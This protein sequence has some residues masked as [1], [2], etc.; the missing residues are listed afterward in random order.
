MTAVALIGCDGAGKTTIAE[1]LV[2]RRPFPARYVYMGVNA[3]SS[4]ISLP[5]T[6]LVYEMKVRKVRRERRKAGMDVEAPVSLHGLEHR[7]DSR[8]RFW[9]GAR[10]LNR[11][12]EE[13]LRLLVSIWYQMR[14]Y[15]VIYDR[16]FLFDYWSTAKA[17]RLSDRIHE[18]FLERV[19]PE[20]D[21]VLFLDAP[22]ETLFARKPEVPVS[23]LEARRDAYLRRGGSIDR[24]ETVD[25]TQPLDTVYHDV[26]SRVAVLLDD[27]DGR[28]SIERLPHE[29]LNEDGR[30]R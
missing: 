17:D 28:G 20:P 4:N 9:A 18:W 19:Y 6:R 23:Y 26:V 29:R 7:K 2:S 24:F 5:T 25:A 14:G 12:A 10:L 15:V 8:G 13:S 3:A 30:T 22:P 21:L 11:L 1:M 27:V 16:H